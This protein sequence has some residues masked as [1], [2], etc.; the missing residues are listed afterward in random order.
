MSLDFIW[1]GL[2]TLKFWC[3]LVSFEFACCLLCLLEI[4]LFPAFISISILLPP[5]RT[6]FFLGVTV[7]HYHP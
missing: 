5:D 7:L 1:R 2:T 4:C 6:E 3:L